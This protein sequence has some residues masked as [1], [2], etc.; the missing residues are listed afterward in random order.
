MWGDGIEKWGGG[1]GKT[2]PWLVTD[3]IARHNKGMGY[4]TEAEEK[5]EGKQLSVPVLL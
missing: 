4:P 5:F 3:N 2:D 1:W